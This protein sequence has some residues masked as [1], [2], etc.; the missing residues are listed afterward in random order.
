MP[1]VRHKT[2][3]RSIAELLI[4][5]ICHY[6]IQTPD[7]NSMELGLNAGI[8]YGFESGETGIL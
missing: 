3:H 2:I 5:M 1:L 8:K 7:L 4:K 6:R